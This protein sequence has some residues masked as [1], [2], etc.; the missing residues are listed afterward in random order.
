MSH[1][2]QVAT[3]G[4]RPIAACSAACSAPGHAANGNPEASSK[5]SE[6]VNQTA[7]VRSVEGG[8]S[9]GT[10]SSTWPDGSRRR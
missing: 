4:S 1:R 10:A 7:L 6:T 2:S 5:S 3:S 9:N 8:I